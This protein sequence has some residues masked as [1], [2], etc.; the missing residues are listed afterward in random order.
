MALTLKTIKPKKISDQ[1]FD[2]LRELIFRGEL[3]PGQK[4]MTERELAEAMGISRTSVRD[5]VHRL[6]AMGL[7]EQRQGQGTFVRTPYSRDNPVAQAIESQDAS[8][9]DLM[10]VRLGLECNAAAMAAMRADEKDIRLMEKS[11]EEMKVEFSSGRLGSNADASFHMAVTYATKNPLHIYMMKLF[12]DYLFTGIR[13]NLSILY[14]DPAN[15]N[16]IFQH[17]TNV[18]QAIKTKNPEA[19]YEAMREHVQFVLDYFESHSEA[20]GPFIKRG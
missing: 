11:L 7:L 12:F 4:I 10:E 16:L 9:T 5:A 3:Q 15:R 2:Q 17:H 6:V 8:L 18:Y 13:E 14:K 19:A 1:V 20:S